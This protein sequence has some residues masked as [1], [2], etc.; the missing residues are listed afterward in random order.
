M[1]KAKKKPLGRPRVA[2]DAKRATLVRVL[3][4]EGEHGELQR[5]AEGAS[6]SVS[7]WVRGAALEKARRGNSV[8]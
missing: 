1:A 6:A 8:A 5:A 4:T 2:A 3:V 7:A